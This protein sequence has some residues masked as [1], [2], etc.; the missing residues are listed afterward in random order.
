MGTA[1]TW[2]TAGY[3]QHARC[4]TDLGMPVLELL[5]PTPGEH[6]LHL[7]CGEI[8][9]TTKKIAGLGCRTTGIDPD[10]LSDL[11]VNTCQNN[12]C[13]LVYPEGTLRQCH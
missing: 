4:V 11:R 1:Q 5:T 6:V 12:G 3:D 8:G 10:G 13:T 9:V 7:G 2:N